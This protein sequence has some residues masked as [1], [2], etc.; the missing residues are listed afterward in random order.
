MELPRV[1]DDNM[2]LDDPTQ[3]IPSSLYSMDMFSQSSSN[4]D[5]L[6]EGDDELGEH[7]EAG[8]NEFTAPQNTVILVDRK[9]IAKHGKLMKSHYCIKRLNELLYKNI[10]LTGSS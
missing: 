6:D 9:E 3:T 8:T 1:E 10:R 2:S 7:C 4:K 5:N